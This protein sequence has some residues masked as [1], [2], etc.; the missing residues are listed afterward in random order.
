MIGFDFTLVNDRLHE[1]QRSNLGDPLFVDGMA[2]YQKQI[3]GG[4]IVVGLLPCIGCT[5]N[6]LGVLVCTTPWIIHAGLL[7][8]DL[9]HG[10]WRQRANPATVLAFPCEVHTTRP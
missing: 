4:A 3:L 9:L 8:S 2:K 1:T 5:S 7:F 10:I 6:A